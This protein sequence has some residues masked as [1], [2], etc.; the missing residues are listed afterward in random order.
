MV[1]IA[2]GLIAFK[3]MGAVFVAVAVTLTVM[4]CASGAPSLELEVNC[5]PFLFGNHAVV[6]TVL[7]FAGA[8]MVVMMPIGLF[9]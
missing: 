2:I 5:F 9:A 4:E 8:V 1:E 3:A 7:G 6:S